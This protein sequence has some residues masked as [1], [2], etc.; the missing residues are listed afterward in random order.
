MKSSPYAEF[1]IK[2][3]EAWE[4][5]LMRTQENLDLWLKV[6]AVWMYLEPVFSSEDI[7]SQMPIEGSKFKEVNYAWHNL[8]NRVNDKP[9]ALTVIKIEELGT[10][11]KSANE[12]LER[13][14]KGLNEYLES[15]RTL[16]P[17]FYF[18]SNDEMLEILSETKEPLRV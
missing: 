9:D 2:D 3:I 8:M 13:V 11:L 17:R 1:M 6:Q 15:K 4:K 10:I 12:K 18:L 14:Q 16:F 7:I 5:I